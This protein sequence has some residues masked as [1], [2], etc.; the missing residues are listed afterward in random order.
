MSR[1]LFLLQLLPVVS[2]AAP[3]L[4]ATHGKIQWGP[5]AEDLTALDDTLPIMCGNLSVPLDYSVSNSSKTLKLELVKLPAQSKTSSGSIL[6]NFGGPGEAS[7]ENFVGLA[8]KLQFMT[9]GHHDL[10]TFNPRGTGKTLT[11]S[12]YED[13]SDGYVAAGP[14]KAGNSS[15]TAPGEIWASASV[16]AD[17]CRAEAEEIG[18]LIGTSFVARDMMEIVNALGENGLKY[19]GFS[20][21]TLLGATVAAMFPDRMDKIVLDGVV[22]WHEYWDSYNLEML[23]DADKTFRS[24]LDGCIAVGEDCALVKG[25]PNVTAVE[26]EES[27]FDFLEDLKYSPIAHNGQILDYTT[28]KFFLFNTLYKPIQWP[29]ITTILNEIIRGDV[30]YVLDILIP[31]SKSSTVSSFSSSDALHGIQLGDSKARTSDLTDIGP[32]LTQLADL[33]KLAGDLLFF[34]TM[35]TAQWQMAASERYRGDYH[36]KTKNPVL[37][38]GNTFDPVT[39]LVS[40]HNVS[41]DF[42]GSVVLEHNG[43]GHTSM[44]QES[45]CTVKAIQAYFLNGTLPKPGSVCEVDI[46]LWSNLTWIDL[47]E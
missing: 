39:P 9:G 25:R 2:Y 1:Y 14:L 5:C 31:K 44:G 32:A 27:I 11:F 8:P 45:L 38:I 28:A 24:L 26:L 23:T 20:Y 17:D 43:H 42:E 29:E 37:F 16:F 21:G 41:S 18:S 22:N 7:D 35:A 19:W 3:V 12:C 13:P 34:R 46:P 10:I 47:L 40:A 15:D 6:L 30:S 36:V 33:S 4:N